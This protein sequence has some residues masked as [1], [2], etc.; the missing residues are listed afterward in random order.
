MRSKYINSTFSHTC[1]TEN[2]F[3][4]IDFLH[5]VEIIA[6][7]RCFSRKYGNSSLRMRSFHHTTT[8]GLISDVIFEFSAP[9]FTRT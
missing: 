9:V 6:V 8:S 1:L 5:D 7:R 2:G 3:R 4:D